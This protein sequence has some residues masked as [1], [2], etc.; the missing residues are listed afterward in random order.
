[1]AKSVPESEDGLGAGVLPK[2]G[3]A[4]QLGGIK[5]YSLRVRRVC[6][7]PIWVECVVGGV[8]VLCRVTWNQRL[9]AG[10]VLD[11]CVEER[12]HY[13]YPRRLGR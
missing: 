1:M 7:S 10:A 3:L 4:G 6:L 11:G 2:N 13:F 12:G 8:V 9:R 5:R